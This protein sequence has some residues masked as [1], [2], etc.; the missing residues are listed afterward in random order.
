MFFPCLYVC[1]LGSFAAFPQTVQRHAWR[2][3]NGDP[4]LA[5]EGE[6]MHKL[7]SSYRAYYGGPKRSKAMQIKT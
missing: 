4:K 7:K 3:I 6:K 5:L 2:W 1:S